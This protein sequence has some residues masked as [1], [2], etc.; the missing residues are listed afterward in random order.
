MNCS[1]LAGIWQSSL[2]TGLLL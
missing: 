1:K 2:V